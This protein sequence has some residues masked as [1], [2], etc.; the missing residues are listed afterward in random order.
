MRAAFEPVLEAARNGK[1][2]D[3]FLRVARA[4]IAV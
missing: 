4:K 1:A 3:A 2:I